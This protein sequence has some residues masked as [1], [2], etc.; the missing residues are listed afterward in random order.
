MSWLRKLFAGR[1]RQ[2]NPTET[3]LAAFFNE[4][5]KDE[6][7]F[8]STI[9]RNILHVRT[10]LDWCGDLNGKRVAD[11]GCGKGRFARIV[12]EENPGA[13]IIGLDI[14]VAMLQHVPASVLPCAGN[15]TALPLATGSCDAAY[16]TE[17]LEH[18]IDID[19]AVAELCRILTPGGR[20]VIIDKNK[21]HWGRLQ[22]PEWEKWFGQRELEDLLKRHCRTVTSHPISYWEEEIPDGLFLVWLAEK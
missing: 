2:P 21:E 4:A 11:V 12:Q 7:H 17:S 20:L 5:S 14:A 8:P 16:A 9:D 18:A 13:T 10:V 19:A 3:A 6:E 15:L 22:T 1:Q